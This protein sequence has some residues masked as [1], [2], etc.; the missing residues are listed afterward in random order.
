MTICLNR[1]SDTRVLSGSSIFCIICYHSSYGP[2][3]HRLP[4][5]VEVLLTYIHKFLFVDVGGVITGTVGTSGFLVIV[6]F[7]YSV[8][9]IILFV[10]NICYCGIGYWGVLVCCFNVCSCFY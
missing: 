7:Y 10:G 2:Y 5:W 4:W 6:V 8:W 1:G 3:Q 9:V